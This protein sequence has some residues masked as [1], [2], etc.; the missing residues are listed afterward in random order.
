MRPGGRP[1]PRACA[2]ALPERSEPS[3]WTLLGP[4]R[5]TFPGASTYDYAAL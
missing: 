1:K 3:V 2:D 4:L 5:A